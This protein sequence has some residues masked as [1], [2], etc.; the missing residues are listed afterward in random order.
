MPLV[1]FRTFLADG[2]GIDVDVF[3]AETDFQTNVLNNRVLVDLDG[4]PIWVV[5]PEDLLLLKLLASRPR[6]LID[7]ADIIFIQGKLD[8]TYLHDWANRL[9]IDDRL[10]KALSTSN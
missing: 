1:K 3:L 7:V 4:K 10:K 5:K 9:N 6:D 8:E 2:K